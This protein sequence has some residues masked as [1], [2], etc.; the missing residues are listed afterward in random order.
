MTVQVKSV[1]V[2]LAV[3]VI[4]TEGRFFYDFLP[5]LLLAEHPYA[6]DESMATVPLLLMAQDRLQVVPVADVQIASFSLTQPLVTLQ[7]PDEPEA[8]PAVQVALPY[9]IW[10]SEPEVPIAFPSAFTVVH[11]GVCIPIPVGAVIAP[12]PSGAYISH[13]RPIAVSIVYAVPT[14]PLPPQYPLPYPTRRPNVTE[15]VP[16][17]VTVTDKPEKPQQSPG[18]VTVTARPDKPQL[19]TVLDF[20]STVQTPPVLVYQPP[21]DSELENRNPPQGVV[22]AG[23]VQSA[24]PTP[25]LSVFINS[26]ESAVLQELRDQANRLKASRT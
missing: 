1:L 11:D 5:P 21:T 19:I 12:V 16:D 13:A 8:L 23:I 22:P 6:V 14:G 2:A 4:A 25:N 18:A 24:A 15:N 7:A 26:K 9:P 20:P 3:L 17:V 10:V